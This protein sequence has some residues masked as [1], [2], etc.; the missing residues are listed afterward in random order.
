VPFDSVSKEVAL[1]PGR[2]WCGQLRRPL[3][4]IT[5]EC[6]PSNSDCGRQADR[7]VSVATAH[8]FITLEVGKFPG[9]RV[10]PSLKACA[11]AQKT[12]AGRMATSS[13]KSL[14]N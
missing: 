1:G 13:C 12:D 11:H 6:F 7:C 2:Y 5:V 4:G 14:G 9:I 3:R 10:F 8:A